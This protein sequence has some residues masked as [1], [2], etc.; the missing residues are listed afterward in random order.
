MLTEKEIE[1]IFAEQLNIKGIQ[2]TKLENFAQDF[3][4]FVNMLN[5]HKDVLIT[6]LFVGNPCNI[7]DKGW[8][9]YVDKRLGFDLDLEIKSFYSQFSDISLRWININHPMYKGKK[10]KK[11]K[12]FDCTTKL[13]VDDDSGT[14]KNM[15]ITSGLQLFYK[16]NCVIAQPDGY[17]LYY[18]NYSHFFAGQLAINLN[19]D[20]QEIGLYVGDDYFAD[21]RPLEMDFA[22]YMYKTIELNEEIISDASK[23]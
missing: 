17:D 5:S 4:A 14:A 13:G 22:S 9:K 2:G 12:L 11:F 19:K 23:E 8:K 16:N 1:T 10:N 21:V 20:K 15:L 18:F 7:G 6:N 3:K